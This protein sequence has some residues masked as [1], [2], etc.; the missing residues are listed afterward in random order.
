MASKITV[1]I[2]TLNEAHNIE[3]CIMGVAPIADEI[4]V[5]DAFS[6]DNTVEHCKKLGVRVEQRKW[7]GYAKSKNYLNS[8]ATHP[9]IFSIDAD[10]VPDEELLA[11][12]RQVKEVGLN[13]NAVYEVNRLT[14]YCGKWIKY[15]GW[16]P[17]RKIR[18]FSNENTKWEGNY[19]H[20]ELV[21]S[22][23]PEVVRLAGH[24]LHYSYYSQEEH[25]DRADRYSAL[26]AQKMYEKG[27]QA[28]WVKPF[29]SAIGRFLSMYI[30]KKGMLDGKAGLQIACISAKSNIF[31]YKELRRLNRG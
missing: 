28:S 27:K 2:I 18:I 17:D 3:R 19:V 25:K 22:N 11:S 8:L 7:E 21:F 20:E 6:T 9:F 12:I 31:K 30:I 23:S 5:L 1:T 13:L 10:E 4:I 29:I 26:T 14:N 15:S 24:L 16:Y